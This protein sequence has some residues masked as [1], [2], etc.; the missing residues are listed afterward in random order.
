VFEALQWVAHATLTTPFV[1][2]FHELSR[3]VAVASPEPAS[4]GGGNTK[5]LGWAALIASCTGFLA[6]AG[7]IILGW[8]HRRNDKPE[9]DI[10]DKAM[11]YLMEQNKALL[12]EQSKREGKKN[13]A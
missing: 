12:K 13:G 3:W 4:G 8:Q 10:R 9:D 2:T 1:V 6:A 11:K 7:T 5:L